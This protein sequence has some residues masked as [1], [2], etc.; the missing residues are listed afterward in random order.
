MDPIGLAMENFDAVGR[1]RDH[2]VGGGAIDATGG[3]PDGTKFDGVAGL[4]Q[5]LLKKPDVF[6]STMTDR[7]LTY[8]LGRGLEYYDA[9]TVRSIVRD[10]RNNNYQF[11]SL[12]MGVINSTPFQMRRSQ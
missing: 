2:Y 10:A 3:F 8:G 5:A 4:K 1:W 12:I 6:V 11:S 7:L 9:P